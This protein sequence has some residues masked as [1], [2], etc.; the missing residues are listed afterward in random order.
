MLS[1]NTAVDEIT[2]SDIDR[3]MLESYGID[4]EFFSDGTLNESIDRKPKLFGVDGFLVFNL[5]DTVERMFKDE[6]FNAVLDGFHGKA[7]DL[8]AYELVAEWSDVL[9]KR[10][11]F[12][13]AS[14]LTK[15]EMLRY[16]EMFRKMASEYGNDELVSWVKSD[17]KRFDKMP[18]IV[19]IQ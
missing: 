18:K 11:V 2:E 13:W 9:L 14:S 4:G 19:R 17:D 1:E 5:E 10:F 12:D 8:D 7:E 15:G 3:S 6:T 16:D